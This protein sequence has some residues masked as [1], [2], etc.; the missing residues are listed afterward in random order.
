[1][2][3]ISTL[4]PSKAHA[5][6]ISVGATTW[7]TWWD[8]NA[9]DDADDEG[10]DVDPAFMYGPALSVKF[11]NDFNLTFVYLYGK[12][13][14][15]GRPDQLYKANIKRSDADLALNY[16]LNDYLKLFGG[17]KYIGFT[18]S[19][20]SF[21]FE[22]KSRDIGPGLGISANFPVAENLFL[23]ANISGMYLWGSSTE[24]GFGVDEDYDCKDAVFNGTLSIA[25]Y[26]AP[27]STVISLG[28]RYQYAKTVDGYG[29]GEVSKFYGF[30]LTATYNFS[31]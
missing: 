17:L 5:V 3:L 31:I 25:Y 19:V 14:A 7:Y 8:H 24:T 9:A 27:A 6:D 15:T 29:D 30:T 23:L 22:A 16:R 28:G 13:D 11:N 10:M 21:D 1:M 4:I 26:I 18:S 12:F 20:T 2:I